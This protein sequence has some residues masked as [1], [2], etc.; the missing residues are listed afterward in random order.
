MSI[1]H[2]L[3]VKIFSVLPHICMNNAIIITCTSFLCQSFQRTYVLTASAEVSIQGGLT[4]P[5]TSNNFEI[6]QVNMTNMLRFI[7]MHPCM[8][9]SE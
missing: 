7:R 1:H 6:A 5:Q 9:V 8:H 4:D 2:H 3:S